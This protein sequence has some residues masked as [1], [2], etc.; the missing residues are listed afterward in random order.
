[1][2]PFL[3]P[4]FPLGLSRSLT[5]SFKETFPLLDTNV[6]V[7][8]RSLLSP[9]DTLPREPLCVPKSAALYLLT[10][11]RAVSWAA[12]HRRLRSGPCIQLSREHLGLCAPQH[13]ISSLPCLFMQ[14]PSG[15]VP[16]FST[17][18]S[19]L[20]PRYEQESREP[21]ETRQ[22]YFMAPTAC[23]MEW[24]EPGKSAHFYKLSCCLPSNIQML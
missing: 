4:S 22:T 8:L 1:M 15:R 18:S 13:L 10:P 21:W 11:L 7:F 9:L 5:F 6:G 16:L 23:P 12:Y 2:H 3:V 14:F 20:T 19:S 24:E 17:P